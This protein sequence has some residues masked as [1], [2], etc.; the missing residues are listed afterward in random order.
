MN[1]F[2]IG[3]RLECLGL[4]LRKALPHVAGLGVGGV[5]IDAL[6][7]LSPERLSETGRR[8]LRQVLRTHNLELTAQG[9]P[10]RHGLDVAENQQ[11]RLE[12]IR[13]VMSQS[14]ELGARRV[15]IEA[16]RVPEDLASPRAALMDE[17]L[18]N[19][20]QHGDRIGVVLAL[21]TGL[22]SGQE[23]RSYL[24]RFDTGSLGVNL[25]PANLLLNRFDVLE[26]VRALHGKLVHSHARDARTGRASR[27]AA[28]VPLGHGD[29]DWLAYL[30]TLEEVEYCGWLII[31]R[32]SGDQRLADIEASVGFLRRIIGMA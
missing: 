1:R 29:I 10:L 16:G 7:D 28:E 4:P 2:K 8:E 19:L 14:Y 30:E 17:A 6:G 31:E 26:S 13:K 20:A 24:D 25:D 11:P 21:E 18:R 23:L 15:V 9:C 3:V 5:Q 32:E 22:E 27:A 12:H